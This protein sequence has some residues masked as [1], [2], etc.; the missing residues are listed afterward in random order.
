MAHSTCTM[1]SNWSPIAISF[2]QF[3]NSQG[4]ICD[5]SEAGICLGCARI[6]SQKFVCC[7]LPIVHSPNHLHAFW[8]QVRRHPKGQRDIPHQSDQ[9]QVWK[10]EYKVLLRKT[11][12]RMKD[13]AHIFTSQ[14]VSGEGAASTPTT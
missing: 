13:S 6:H 10:Q 8:T 5:L 7:S 4:S 1:W 9:L 11:E 12:Q 3:P 14:T 2:L